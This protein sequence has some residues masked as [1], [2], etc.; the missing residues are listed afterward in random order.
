MKQNHAEDMYQMLMKKLVDKLGF[1]GKNP[2]NCYSLG[3]DMTVFYYR[4][5]IVK[6]KIGHFVQHCLESYSDP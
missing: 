3:L 5:K 6:E 1:Y 4:N 2:E